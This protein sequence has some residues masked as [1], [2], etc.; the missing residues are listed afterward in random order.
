MRVLVIGTGAVGSF[1]GSLLAKQGV[2]VSVLARSDYEHVRQHGI[3][4]ESKLGD[5]HFQPRRVVR[6]AA[7]LAEQPDYV[8]LCVKL[9]KNAD[10]VAPAQKRHRRRLNLSIP[11]LESVYALMKLRELRLARG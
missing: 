11:H 10:R 4:I 7:E 9:V 1:Y 6:D 2:A 8:L 5:Y 3:R